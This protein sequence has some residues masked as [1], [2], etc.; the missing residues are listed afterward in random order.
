MINSCYNM[1]MGIDRIYATHDLA[2]PQMGGSYVT[3]RELRFNVR[4]GVY[5][6]ANERRAISIVRDLAG[7]IKVR[8][9]KVL[10]K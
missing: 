1:T 5:H 2:G 7:M 4:T 3:G 6:P 10:L 8:V 9:S